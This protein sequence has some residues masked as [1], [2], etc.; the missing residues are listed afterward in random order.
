MGENDA[1]NK[2]GKGSEIETEVVETA[3]AAAN[4]QIGSTVE[5]K[6]EDESDADEDEDED[7]DDDY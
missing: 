5:E 3:L 7:E 4:H 6:N 1:K 2:G